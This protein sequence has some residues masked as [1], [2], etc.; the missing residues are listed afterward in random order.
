MTSVFSHRPS[1]REIA[2]SLSLSSSLSVCVCIF[3]SVSVL[4]LCLRLRLS[5]C[6][7]AL[8]IYLS[9]SLFLSLNYCKEG[10]HLP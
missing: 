4:C 1:L 2:L 7:S 6:L 9:Q 3:D 10:D 8:S 5:V